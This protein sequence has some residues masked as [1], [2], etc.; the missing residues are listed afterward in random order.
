MATRTTGLTEVY[1][2]YC[3]AKGDPQDRLR[4]YRLVPKEGSPGLW[5]GPYR[6]QTDAENAAADE[7]RSRN[8]EIV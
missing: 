4:F 6:D 8:L 3:G 2:E 5:R 7:A 1:A